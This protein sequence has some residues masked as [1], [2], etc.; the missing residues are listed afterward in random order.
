MPGRHVLEDTVMSFG[1]VLAG[2]T[3]VGSA[4]CEFG[5]KR[6]T[7]GG[8]DAATVVSLVCLLVGV[9]GLLSL[10]AYT[11][12]LPVPLAA[13]WPPA[14]ASAA[15]SAVTATLLTK[16]YSNN[17]ISLVAPFNSALPVFQF[18]M[19]TFVLRDETSLP[20]RKVAGV[21][22]VCTCSFWL[23]RSG[24][25]VPG[26][27]TVPLLPPGAV[28]VLVCCA[29]WSVVTKFDQ[30]A[31]TAAGSPIIYVCWAK[32]LT[33]LWAAGGATLGGL[34]SSNSKSDS[35]SGVATSP[36]HLKAPAAPSPRRAA[37]PTRAAPRKSPRNSVG[38]PVRLG[39]DDNWGTRTRKSI[40]TGSTT[41]GKQSAA[42]P[43]PVAEAR[44][45]RKES[46][47]R[48]A[49]ERTLRLLWAEPTYMLILCAIALTEAF[50]M[51]CYFAA[52][53]RTSKVY[54]VA[55][56]KG[57]NLLVSSVGG[58]VLLGEETKGRVFPVIGVVSGVVLM[59]M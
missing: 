49:F 2:V 58:W 52:L 25:S 51:G 46:Y 19:T 15:L 10:T 22:V 27:T 28:H 36:A 9:A 56:K 37:S 29:I 23:A 30:L 42:V 39:V 6:L 48:G 57:G 8:L 5:R 1:L 44:G 53:T 12:S 4:G 40:E 11:G 13:F 21:F 34:L 45:S 16:A 59:S 47:G 18:L 17:D 43:L 32:L 14:L 24:R 33:G 35:S 55:I 31:T 38:P 20:P 3:A 50:Y 7:K 26:A 41:L 54:V